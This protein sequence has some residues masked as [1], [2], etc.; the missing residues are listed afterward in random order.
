MVFILIKTI[1]PD[2]GD[3]IIPVEAVGITAVGIAQIKIIAV[4]SH[5]ERFAFPALPIIGNGTAA[6]RILRTPVQRGTLG[7]LHRPATPSDKKFQQNITLYIF[8]S[9]VAL[10]DGRGTSSIAVRT[11]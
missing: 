9:E 6:P 1:S 5:I 3:K 2:V 11:P 10:H 4:V 7:K 8:G